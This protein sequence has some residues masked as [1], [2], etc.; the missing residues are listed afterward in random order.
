V[1]GR[2]HWRSEVGEREVGRLREKKG[3]VGR[4]VV[5]GRENGNEGWERLE[6]GGLLGVRVGN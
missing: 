6:K 5:C 2:L 3:V 4:R 1:E